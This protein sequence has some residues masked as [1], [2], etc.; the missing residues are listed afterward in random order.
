MEIQDIQYIYLLQTREFINSNL[1]VYKVGKT[2]QLN[3][4]RFNSYPKNHNEEGV[5]D[6]FMLALS[7]FNEYDIYEKE[8][9]EIT[10]DL[11]KKLNENQDINDIKQNIIDLLDKY[12]PPSPSLTRVAIIYYINLNQAEK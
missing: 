6:V 10:N 1:P 9:L 12:R 11:V 2:K 5:F 7:R 3:N 8:I 4:L